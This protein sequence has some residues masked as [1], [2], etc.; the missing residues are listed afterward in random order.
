MWAIGTC[1][2]CGYNRP[3]RYGGQYYCIFR[4]RERVFS[5]WRMKYVRRWTWICDDCTSQTDAQRIRNR[6]KKEKEHD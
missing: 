6:R 4:V 2:K 5:F 1:H 3:D